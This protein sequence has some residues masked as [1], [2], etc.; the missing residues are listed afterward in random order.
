MVFLLSKEIVCI[1]TF[2]LLTIFAFFSQLFCY[3][4]ISKTAMPSLKGISLNVNGMQSQPK[5][6]AIFSMLRTGGYDFA[7]IQESHCTPNIESLWQREWGGYAYF[8]NGRSNARGVMTLL[9]KMSDIKVVQQV[10]DQQGRFLILQI[11]KEG[12]SFTLGNVYAPTQEQV[13]E[14]IELIDLLEKNISDLNPQNIILGGDFNSCID[15]KLDKA[16]T[17][18]SSHQTTEIRYSAR[19]AAVCDTLHLFDAWRRLNP[20]SRKYSFKAH[21]H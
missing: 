8:S 15:P 9:P 12:T 7:F 6:R 1:T 10:R 16:P 4:H 18:A 2:M 3:S 20:T 14:Q 11:E 13:Q 19:I 5:R 21:S 17:R